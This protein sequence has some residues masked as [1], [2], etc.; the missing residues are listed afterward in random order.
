MKIYLCAAVIPRISEQFYRNG[1]GHEGKGQDLGNVYEE[2]RGL[3]SE[4]Q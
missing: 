3:V 2:I 4:G 1:I